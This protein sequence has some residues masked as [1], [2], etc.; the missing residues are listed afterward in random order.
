M[1]PNTIPEIILQQ[2]GGNKFRAMTGARQFVYTAN[3]LIFWLPA[4]FAKNRI[5]TVAITLTDADL[6]DIEFWNKTKL[7]KSCEGVYAESLRRT[8]TDVT[9]LDCTL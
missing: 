3:S 9:G 5:S 7:V 6:Y 2:L 8:F 4:N 1:Q